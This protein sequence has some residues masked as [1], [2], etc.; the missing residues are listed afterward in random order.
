MCQIE[1]LLAEVISVTRYGFPMDSAVGGRG[2][3]LAFQIESQLAGLRA[4]NRFMSNL[5]LSLLG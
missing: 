5:L 1:S 4:L 3:C 2:A